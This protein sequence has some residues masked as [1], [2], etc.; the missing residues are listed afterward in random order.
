M[1]LQENNSFVKKKIIEPVKNL[2]PLMKTS[3]K[4]SWPIMV[5]M[6]FEFFMSMTDIYIAGRFGEAVK[7]ATGLASQVYSFFIMTGHALTIGA[8]S[9]LSRLFTSDD[10]EKFRSAVFTSVIS[11]FSFG[12][13]IC[14]IGVTFSSKI[15]TLLNAPEEVKGYASSLIKIYFL[16]IIF[17]MTLIN[18]NGVLRSCKRVTVTM[19]VMVFAAILNI[20]LVLYFYN[21]TDLGFQGIAISTAVSITSASIINMVIM[22]RI[23]SKTYIFSL[24][25]LKQILS[26]G[27]PGGIVSLSWQLGGTAL[28]AVLGMLSYNSVEIMAAYATGLRIESAIFMPAFAFNMANAVIVGNLMGEKKYNEAYKSGLTTAFIS[29]SVVTV[30]IVV[31]VLNARSIAELLEHNPVVVNEIVKYIYICMIAEPFIALNLA[32]T[33]ALNGAGDT[34]ATMFYAM[35]NVW[36]LRL[37][38]AYILGIALGFHAAGIWWALNSGFF[39]QSA[40]STRRFISKKWQ[41][42]EII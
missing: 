24:P 1:M 32:M 8:V 4:M 15:A 38:L 20:I 13:V 14:I 41:K 19:G 17:H 12:V 22:F 23:I 6:V 9:V 3:W 34:K 21:F 5:M 31:I 27:W 28:Y 36:V 25:I 10:K 16:G 26:I 30:M 37:P 18:M 42:I 11:A 7:A 40:L 35:L 39:L 2:L 33:G 29:V